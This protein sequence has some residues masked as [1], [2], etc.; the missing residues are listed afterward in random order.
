MKCADSNCKSYYTDNT[1]KKEKLAKLIHDGMDGLINTHKLNERP[2]IC[3]RNLEI[4]KSK[5]N[6]SN[7]EKIIEGF[8]QIMKAVKNTSCKIKEAD[9]R[10]DL[11]TLNSS[12]IKFC[13]DNHQQGGKRK[14]IQKNNTKKKK[15]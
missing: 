7:T 6:V 11:N 15:T 5:Y 2:K 3:G 8:M 14:I 4:F 1:A 12:I 10:S 13:M 9:L